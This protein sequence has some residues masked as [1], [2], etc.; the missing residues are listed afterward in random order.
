VLERGDTS[1]NKT[2]TIQSDKPVANGNGAGKPVLD[3]HDAYVAKPRPMVANGST[4]RIDTPVGKAYITVNT[5]AAG[6][7]LEV[8]INVGKPGA[9]VYAMAEALG[10]TISM[11]LRFNTQLTPTDRVRRIIEEL[12]GIGGSRT[13]G[14]GKNSVKSL[15]DAVAKV[16]GMHYSLHNPEAH[17]GNGHANVDQAATNA[18]VVVDSGTAIAAIQTAEANAFTQ[19][20]LTVPVP[21]KRANFDLCPKCGDAAL[22]HEEGCKKC[23]TCGYSAC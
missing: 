13:L 1:A 9:D 17:V 20:S 8:F 6:E 2:S 4:Y 14:F 10:R 3:P 11:S 19:P 18:K 15:P 21:K 22:A 16:L 5:N 12:E 7:P 23:Y